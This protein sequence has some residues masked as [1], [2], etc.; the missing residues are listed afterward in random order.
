MSTRD[1]VIKE[2]CSIVALA[3]RSIGDY[4]HASDCFCCESKETQDWRYRNDGRIVEYVRQAVVEKLEREGVLV[5]EE[6]LEK[7]EAK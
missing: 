7:G 4:S 2:M 6:F 1:E 5:I 3:Y